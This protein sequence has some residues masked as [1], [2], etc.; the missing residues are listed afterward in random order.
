MNINIGH[1]KILIDEVEAWLGHYLNN[2]KAFLWDLTNHCA[3]VDF[4]DKNVE[5]KVN[6]GQNIGRIMKNIYDYSPEMCEHNYEV[7]IG[8]E[9][10][11]S[12]HKN[13][14]KT[15]VEILEKILK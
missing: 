9:L 4:D 1:N 2:W 8:N 5:I 11:R 6:S 7:D 12:H 13:Y 10:W 3:V 15:S 14:W